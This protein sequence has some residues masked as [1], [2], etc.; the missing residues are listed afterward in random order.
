MELLKLLSDRGTVY[1]QGI[2]ESI[3]VTV[4]SQVVSLV[5]FGATLI[6]KLGWHQHVEVL[7]Y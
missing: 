2:F 4:I 6:P 7:K 5:C 1:K 3:K